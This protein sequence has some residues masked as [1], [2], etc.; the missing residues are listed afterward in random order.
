LNQKKAF[1]E[2]NTSAIN[3]LA[4]FYKL[5]DQFE[6]TKYY[7]NRIGNYYVNSLFSFLGYQFKGGVENANV[8][9]LAAEAW[10]LGLFQELKHENKH[11]KSIKEPFT[12]Q[13]LLRQVMQIIVEE[14]AFIDNMKLISGIY[15]LD[16]PA[17]E[18][19]RI[20]KIFLVNI[21]VAKH[22]IL[23]DSEFLEDPKLDESAFDQILLRI[24]RTAFN[25]C[26]NEFNSAEVHKKSLELFQMYMDQKNMEKTED[27]TLDN[28]IKNYFELKKIKPDSLTQISMSSLRVHLASYYRFCESNINNLLLEIEYFNE[29]A[30]SVLFKI[31]NLLSFKNIS[32]IGHKYF[33][34]VSNVLQNGAKNLR[35]EGLI[36][37]T[38]SIY[39]NAQEVKV[40]SI[41]KVKTKY[42][43][44][45]KW[46]ISTTEDIETKYGPY[47][48]LFQ[49]RVYVAYGKA[50]H[51]TY[52]PRKMLADYVIIPSV[53]LAAKVTD[54]AINFTINTYNLGKEN[55][56]QLVQYIETKALSVAHGVKNSVF[57]EEPIVKVDTQAKE[58]KY[59]SISISKKLFIADPQKVLEFLSTVLEKVKNFDVYETGVMVYTKT[60]GT[61]TG[62]KNYVI[63]T[64]RRFL[65]LA[66]EDED[67]C[68]IGQ[69]SGNNYTELGHVKSD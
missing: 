23:K 7:L 56:K 49:E 22:D 55:T 1:Q 21:H 63:S 28:Y 35:L 42:T 38:R 58:N 13:K 29:N 10:L 50:L 53:N 43:D 41:A 4:Y 62:A 6:K 16:E 59:I 20:F 30:N 8:F 17:L 14:H 52:T 19:G 5:S 33:E 45:K 44:L 36:Q 15:G 26:L 18:D 27:R 69:R 24:F 57:G 60:K 34:L 46:V 61:V 25:Y 40:Q 39:D 67:Q 64:Y 65:E 3:R 9:H 51:L 54:S 12:F 66:T 31:K 48:R 2:E 32:R 11:L 68:S 47:Y 37:F